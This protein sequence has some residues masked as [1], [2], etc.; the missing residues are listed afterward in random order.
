[1]RPLLAARWLRSQRSNAFF[2]RLAFCL[3]NRFRIGLCHLAIPLPKDP[4][5]TRIPNSAPDSNVPRSRR[6]LPI[7]ACEVVWWSR[8]GR[9]V[10]D[11]SEMRSVHLIAALY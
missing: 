11:V 10:V 5:Y 4:S 9:Q 7:T 3:C 1:M 6:N 2:P 8:H